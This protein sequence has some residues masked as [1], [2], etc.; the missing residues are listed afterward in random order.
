MV[1]ELPV[2]T[3]DGELRWMRFSLSI[4]PDKG[5]I[6][7]VI[8][9]I[10][11]QKL[12]L[13][14]L[15]KQREELS[16]F[17]HTMSHDLKNIFHNMLG[18]I[19]L[20]E[21]ERNFDHLIKLRSLLHE[22]SEMV[23]HSVALADAGLIIEETLNVDLDS[24]VKEVAS[25]IIPSRVEFSQ[26]EMPIIS[27]DQRKVAQ[28]FRN[29]FDNAIQHGQPSKIEVSSTKTDGEHMIRIANDGKTIPD[30]H[31]ARIFQRGF[32]TSKSGQGFGLAIVKRLVEAHGWTIK[33][34][35]ERETTF[36]IRIPVLH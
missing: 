18:F 36:E 20:W 30:V 2:A 22:T 4:W 23:D 6:E 24:L 10:T 32:T 28:I 26:E 19:E 16:D 35:D 25:S 29:L 1:T 13:E 14:M 21:E 9:D 5:Y 12:A 15:K 8:V 34:L 11:D 31:R 17:A 7:G 27:A 3:T 33:L